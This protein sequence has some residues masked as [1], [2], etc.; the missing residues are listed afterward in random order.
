MT[1]FTIYIVDRAN[2]LV[3]EHYPTQ[4]AADSAFD[5]WEAGGHD[6]YEDGQKAALAKLAYGR[7]LVRQSA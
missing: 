1:N 5:K 7:F 6:V 4:D 3:V 2:Q